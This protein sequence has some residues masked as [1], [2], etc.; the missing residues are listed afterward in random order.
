M[1]INKYVKITKD[2]I[3]RRSGLYII[4]LLSIMISGLT[5]CSAPPS[6]T[7]SITTESVAAKAGTLQLYHATEDG[8]EPDDDRYQ[9]MQPDNLSAALEEVIEN[10]QVSE[11]MVIEKYAIDEYRNITLFI[12]ISDNVTTEE[13]LLNQAAIVK[14]IEGLEVKNIAITL[15]DNSGNAIETATYTDASFYYYED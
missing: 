3:G 7:I 9:L 2:F 8:V 12:K 4:V 14:S 15:Q 11:G 6:D 5:G 1:K 13:R 10:M